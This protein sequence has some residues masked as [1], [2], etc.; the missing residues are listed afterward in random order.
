LFDHVETG[1]NAKDDGD[2][3]NVT[4]A[5]DARRLSMQVDWSGLVKKFGNAN[6]EASLDGIENYLLAR[7]TTPANRHR[8]QQFVHAAKSD[9]DQLRRAF[10]AHMS[11]PEY[12]LS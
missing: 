4:N 2:I 11:L 6:S 8:I 5:A 1:I 3:N 10:I 12:Q 7:R 9:E